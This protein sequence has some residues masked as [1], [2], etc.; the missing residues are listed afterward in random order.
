MARGFWERLLAFLVLPLTIF[1]CCGGA[2]F[3]HNYLDSLAPKLG[4]GVGLFVSSS[5]VAFYVVCG[6][7][8]GVTHREPLRSGVPQAAGIVAG[9]LGG[10]A[11]LAWLVLGQFPGTA[12]ERNGGYLGIVLLLVGLASLPGIVISEFDRL[13]AEA[14]AQQNAQREV[15]Q[16][17]RAGELPEPDTDV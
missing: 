14:W 10:G 16:R 3:V 7:V 4:T 15:Q 1:C 6:L 12:L 8:Y 17:A 5:A 2:H 13:H 11:A 9:A